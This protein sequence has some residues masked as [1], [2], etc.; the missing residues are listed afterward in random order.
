MQAAWRVLAAVLVSTVVAGCGASQPAEQ[1]SDED[2]PGR[3]AQWT[4]R[5]APT[6]F[7]DDPADTGNGWLYVSGDVVL[8]S[9]NDGVLAVNGRTGKPMWRVSQIDE[10]RTVDGFRAY[11]PGTRPVTVLGGRPL[12]FAGWSVTGERAGVVAL[13]GVTGEPVWR[14]EMDL[15]DDVLAQGAQ[16]ISTTEAGVLAEVTDIGSDRPYLMMMLG[17]STGGEVWSKRGFSAVGAT[18][19]VVVGKDPGG[20]F[21]GLDART[22]RQLWRL[23]ERVAGR[24]LRGAEFGYAGQHSVVFT[25][26]G[27][28]VVLDSHTG[29]MRLTRPTGG[30]CAGQGRELAVCGLAGSD[31]DGSQRPFAFDPGA[32]AEVSLR[33]ILA[34]LGAGGRIT[35]VTDEY[36]Y[37]A[38]APDDGRVYDADSGELVTEGAT[39]SPQT[40]GNRFG[41]YRS[42]DRTWSMHPTPRNTP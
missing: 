20:R 41:I 5:H 26:P 34:D 32:G 29:R 15:P 40:V 11:R 37:A 30:E 7:T 27:L 4:L 17:P 22:G 9:D 6:E 38:A 8:T 39:V 23:P 33:R 35:G 18:H 16:V 28:S 3:G 25:G 1:S 24:S 21:V 31:G 10:Q 19:D 36:V 13:S 14:R 12:V 2:P 42:S